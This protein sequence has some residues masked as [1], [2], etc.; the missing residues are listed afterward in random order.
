M[1]KHS[2]VVWADTA[3]VVKNPTVSSVIRIARYFM[4]FAFP[5]I[6]HATIPETYRICQDHS[7]GEA[8]TN[9]NTSPA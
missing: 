8:G 6:S 3:V 9:E 7:L 2:G 4:I 5:A 1:L